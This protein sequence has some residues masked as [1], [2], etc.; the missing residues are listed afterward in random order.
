MRPFSRKYTIHVYRDGKWEKWKHVTMWVNK[1]PPDAEELGHLAGR[2]LAFIDP[3]N[4]WYVMDVH[5]LKGKIRQSGGTE[6]LV[7]QC[8]N[9]KPSMTGK[10]IIMLGERTV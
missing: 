9:V 5:P 10:Q 1:E 6:T 2:M 3:T 4:T 7:I 8:L